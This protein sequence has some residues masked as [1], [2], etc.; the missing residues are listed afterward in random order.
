MCIRDRSLLCELLALYM[1]AGNK[2]A[3]RLLAQDHFDW[4]D[5]YDAAL[6]ERAER[7][8][9]ASAFD[10]EERAALAR[11][12]GQV[13]AYVALLGELARH[14]GQG[15]P[16]PNEAKTAPTREERKEAK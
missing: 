12:I 5:A 13:R 3:A 15:A 16:T 7:A 1:E 10:E 14:A 8:A 11:G 2:E 6:D 4:L 9:S